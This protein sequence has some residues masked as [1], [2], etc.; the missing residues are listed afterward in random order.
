LVALACFENSAE[1]NALISVALL[2][3]L[4][5]A[6]PVMLLLTVPLGSLP[7]LIVLL[8]LVAVVAVVAVVA[9]SLG[10]RMILKTF[11]FSGH[12]TYKT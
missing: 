1:G 5:A 10:L 7:M 6:L 8:L 9:L 12:K 11:C 3:A 2:V 4:L